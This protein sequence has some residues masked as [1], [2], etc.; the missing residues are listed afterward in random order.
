LG[1]TSQLIDH[2]GADSWTY[3]AI[4]LIVALQLRLSV[5]GFVDMYTLEER[6]K[7]DLDFVVTERVD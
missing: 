7:V 2:T 3:F 4:L 6:P 5:Q 1:L